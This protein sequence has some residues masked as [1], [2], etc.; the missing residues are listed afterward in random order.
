MLTKAL[1]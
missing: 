1:L